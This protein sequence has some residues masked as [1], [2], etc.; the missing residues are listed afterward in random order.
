MLAALAAFVLIVVLARN[1][2]PSEIAVLG[3]LLLVSLTAT[4]WLARDLIRTPSN[5]PEAKPAHGNRIG[6]E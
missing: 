3:P 2:D 4:W 5:F 6:V 1:R